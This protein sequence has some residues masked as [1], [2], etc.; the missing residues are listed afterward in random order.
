MAAVSPDSGMDA[1]KLVADAARTIGGGGRPNPE[2]T[3]VGGKAPERLPRPSNRHG[4]QPRPAESDA[5]PGP[6]PGVQADRGGG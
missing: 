2:V 4:R 6:G 1:G 3:A 5:G